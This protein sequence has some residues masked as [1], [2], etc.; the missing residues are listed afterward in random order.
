[1]GEEGCVVLVRR[2]VVW[3]KCVMTMRG[4]WCDDVLGAYGTNQIPKVTIACIKCHTHIHT[5]THT[6]THIH[7]HT[8]T[9]T[10]THTHTHAHKALAF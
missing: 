4:V 6:H 3:V 7:I 9:H 8:H 2:G 5:H 10:Y 1:M